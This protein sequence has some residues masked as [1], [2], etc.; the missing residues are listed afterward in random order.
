M[1]VYLIIVN[2]NQKRVLGTALVFTFLFPFLGLIM[3]L[4]HW[5]ALW[6]KNVFWLA[7]IYMAF[8]HIYAPEGGVFGQG[9]DIERYVRFL[10][11]VYN[12]SLALVDVLALNSRPDYYQPIVTYLVATISGEGHVLYL[13]FGIVF[14]YFYS[15]N[16]WYVLER[17]PRTF[18]KQIYFLVA[19]YFLICPIWNVGGVRMWTALHVFCYGALP[20]LF[21][22]DRRKLYWAFLSIFVHFSFLLPLAFLFIYII[23]PEKIKISKVLQVVSLGVFL[24]TFGM[25]VLEIEE[26]GLLLQR[27]NPAFYEENVAGYLGEEYV[28]VVAEREES[29]SLFYQVSM[30]INQYV[31]LYLIIVVWFLIRKNQGTWRNSIQRLFSFALLFYALAN[32]MAIVPSGGRYITIAQMFVVPVLLFV[33]ASTICYK[34]R[35]I[36]NVVLMSL[37]ILILFRVRTGAES[38]GINLL[39]GNF[40]TGMALETNV[41]FISSLMR[42]F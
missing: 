25:N 4:Y 6:A 38:Y 2:Q 17:L 23:L 5:R 9:A 39:L 20:Y 18:P 26:I 15:R 19:I 21:E 8:I 33:L 37:A 31:I 35:K 42:I 36:T 29:R 28:G 12:Q 32:V 16:M 40:I 24:L 41:S 13:F 11:V 10:Y 1:N 14:G 22:R 7:C 34:Y 30:F 3:S 27:I